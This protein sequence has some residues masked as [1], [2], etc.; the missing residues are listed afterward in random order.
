MTFEIIWRNPSLKYIILVFFLVGFSVY[1]LKAEDSLLMLPMYGSAGVSMSKRYCQIVKHRIVCLECSLRSPDAEFGDIPGFYR[2]IPKQI[3]GVRKH[4]RRCGPAYLE[5]KEV[6]EVDW[7]ENL[8]ADVTAITPKTYTLMITDEGFTGGAH[9][10][11][12]FEYRNY[13]RKTGRRLGYKDLFKG[14]FNRTLTAIAERVYRRSAGLAPDADL[15][16]EAGWYENRFV[17]PKNFAITTRGLLLSYNTYEVTPYVAEPPKFL[18]SYSQIRSLID[19]KGPLAFALDPDHPVSVDEERLDAQLHL[20]VSKIDAQTLELNA[21]LLYPPDSDIAYKR[22]WLTLQFPGI[23]GSDAILGHES[24]EG[25]RLGIYPAGSQLYHYKAK[26]RIH[27]RRLEVEL[28]TTDTDENMNIHNLQLR[29]R[30]PRKR[31]FIIYY[32]FARQRQD[33]TIDRMPVEGK[34]GQQGLPNGIL[35]WGE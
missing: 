4:Y 27:A 30:I 8:T 18:L 32:R 17:L 35:T 6:P 13:L 14:D 1:T 16:E 23:K 24:D 5:G 22:S 31:P 19:P 12:S 3:A 33:G 29:L 7:Y 2:F 34:V 21:T 11:H 26:K 25:N 20:S 15:S 10:F 28:E 9:E